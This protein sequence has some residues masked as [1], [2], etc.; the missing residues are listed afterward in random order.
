MMHRGLGLAREAVSDVLR[1]A[2]RLAGRQER[3]RENIK[4]GGQDE[5]TNRWRRELDEA[6]QALKKI[7]QERLPAL[8]QEE[9]SHDSRLREALKSLSAEWSK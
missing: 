5:L 9:R 8:R 6:E 1:E 4:A 7:E 3:L 2:E